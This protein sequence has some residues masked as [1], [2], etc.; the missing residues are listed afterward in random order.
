MA[1]ITLAVPALVLVLAHW[2]VSQEV[3]QKQGAIILLFFGWVTGAQL[4]FVTYR[5]RSERTAHLLTKVLSSFVVIVLGYTLISHVF[6]LFLYPDAD[7]RSLIH[8]A[9][10]FNVVVF[11]IL[12]VLT[13]VVI[14]L[15]WLVTYYSE[16][17]GRR[18]HRQHG[19]AWLIFYAMVSREFYLADIYAWMTRVLM[20]TAESLNIWFRWA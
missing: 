4:I 7:F 9:S 2:L 16:Q 8:G 3:F 14:V 6:E 13:A 20:R 19:R 17:N 18:R 10:S 5:M 11:D 12:I 15:G 1:V